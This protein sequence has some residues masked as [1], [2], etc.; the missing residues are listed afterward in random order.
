[1]WKLLEFIIAYCLSFV[2]RFIP[3]Y[4]NA[5]LISERGYDARDNGY[6]FF[7][8]L[9]TNH[10][11]I[12]AYY[13]ISDDNNLDYSRVSLL[14]NLIKYKSMK[15]KALFIIAKCIVSVHKGTI[16]PWNY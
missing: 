4:R 11:E 15:H 14:G 8:Y 1:T 5:W 10:P 3:G 12:N 13:L 2:Y 9:R 7:K 6:H 16:E